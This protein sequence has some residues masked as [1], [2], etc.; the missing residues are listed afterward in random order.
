MEIDSL[1]ALSAWFGTADQKELADVN[2]WNELPLQSEPAAFALELLVFSRWASLDGPAALKAC[3]AQ[4]KNRGLLE[5]VFKSWM[6]NGDAQSAIDHALAL[7]RSDSDA[8]P[9]IDELLA[10]WYTQDPAAAISRAR[11]LAVSEDRLEHDA[12]HQVA[13]EAARHSLDTEGVDAALNFIFAWPAPETHDKLLV[14]LLTDQSSGSNI[15]LDAAARILAQVRDAKSIA[16]PDA[17]A[18][19]ASRIGYLFS[20]NNAAEVHRWCASLP[21]GFQPLAVNQ[22]ARTLAERGQWRESLA[23]LHAYPAPPGTYA[24]AYNKAAS[25]AAKDGEMNEALRLPGQKE[26][27]DPFDGRPDLLQD[28]IKGDPARRDILIDFI[29]AAETAGAPSAAT[30]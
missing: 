12:A 5:A 11:E 24:T 29:V 14:S 3:L 2:T 28:W 25:A 27:Q 13:I 30:R 6:R 9:L 4:T 19:F 18:P 17:L 1:M 10:A 21:A 23:W 20:T 7:Q 8:P 22:I 26:P 15:D 16:S